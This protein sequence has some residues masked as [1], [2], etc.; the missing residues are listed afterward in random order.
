M[1][2][3]SS[4]LRL[5]PEVKQHIESM[6]A[7]GSM[8]LDEL[9]ENLRQQFPDEDGLPSR[10]A[11][12]R[13]GQKL[14]KRLAAI[15]ASTEVAKI[16]HAQTGDREDTRSGALTA[17]IQSELFESIINLQDASDTNMPPEKRVGMLAT[18]AKHVATLTRSSVYLK[19]F[20]VEAEQRIRSELLAEQKA[21]LDALGKKGGVTEE[22]K[23]AI[24]QFLGIE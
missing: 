11:I 5:R 22:T 16:I 18:A 10:A 24:R 3:K 20:Q 4:I 21:K 14:E 17:L 23:I 15:R 1:G 2:R 19:K 13:Y 8:T 12:G 6:L 7:E 9:I